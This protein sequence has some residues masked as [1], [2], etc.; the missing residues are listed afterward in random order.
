MN[1]GVTEAVMDSARSDLSVRIGTAVQK[2]AMDAA[3]I[4]GD[5]L[6]ELMASATG[7]GQKLDVTY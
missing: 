7:V 2:K 3:K 1:M 6:M 4:Q 5:M